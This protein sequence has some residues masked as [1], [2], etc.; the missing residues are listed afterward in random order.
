MLESA[1]GVACL[2]RCPSLSIENIG[3]CL[4]G[5]EGRAGVEVLDN[6]RRE[7]RHI[8]GKKVDMSNTS[9]ICDVLLEI[10]SSFRIVPTTPYRKLSEANKGCATPPVKLE[11]KISKL[12]GYL[13]VVIH[14]CTPHAQSIYTCLPFAQLKTRKYTHDCT[15]HLKLIINKVKPRSPLLHL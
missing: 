7:H 2:P 15:K 1:Q 3:V 6:Y 14:R 4:G 12:A 8:T 13:E 11:T 5:R 10:R 9:S